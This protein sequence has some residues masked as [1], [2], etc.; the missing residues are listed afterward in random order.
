MF[1][2]G[3]RWLTEVSMGS[4]K[5]T[6]HPGLQQ[7]QEIRSRCGEYGVVHWET[8]DAGGGGGGMHGD[9]DALEG[10]GPR[11]QPRGG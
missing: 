2:G 3:T 8:L 10:K 6:L 7:N 5:K 11:R 9:R 1:D 4:D